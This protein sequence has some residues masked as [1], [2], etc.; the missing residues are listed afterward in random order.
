MDVKKLEPESII[1]EIGVL[2]GQMESVRATLDNYGE[3]F[4][5]LN[6][7]LLNLSTDLHEIKQYQDEQKKRSE[8]KSNNKAE[9]RRFSSQNTILILSAVIGA[10]TGSIITAILTVLKG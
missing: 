2:K 6:A 9:D 5:A 3:K 10:C 7:T 4:D 8:N 1:M